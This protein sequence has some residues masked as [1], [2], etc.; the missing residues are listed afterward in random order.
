ME[1]NPRG[2]A[3]NNDSSV[4]AIF[5]YVNYVIK[6]W[7][8]V[9]ICALLCAAIGFSYAYLSY[10]PK[11]SSNIKFVTNNRAEGT[12]ALGQSSSDL[13]AGG[14]LANNYRVLLTTTR[15]LLQKVADEV[16]GMTYTQVASCIKANVIAE[17][18][19]VDF[20]ITTDNADKS[21]AIARAFVHNYDDFAQRAFPS[22]T[23][24]I[25]DEPYKA[26]KANPDNSK[27]LYTLAGFVIGAF[28]A[29]AVCCLIVAAKDTVKSSDDI[30]KKLDMK[31]IGSVGKV[32]K[33]N[34]KSAILISDKNTGFSFV[35]TF[36]LI[37]TKVESFA[38]KENAKTFVI[39]ST[40]EDEGKTTISCNL[41]LSLAKNGKSVLLIDGDLRKPAVSGTLNI[42]ANGETGLYGIIRGD[43][44]AAD[45]VRYSDKY[46][47]F[48]MLNGENIPDAAEVLSDE[49]LGKI[50]KELEKEFDYI[51]IDSAPAGVI[52]D[53]AILASEADAIIL[54]VRED[55]ASIRRIR[56][57]IEDL[58]ISNTEIAGCVYNIAEGGF[59]SKLK[60]Y[61]G[62]RKYG[63]G[64][65]YGYGRGYGYGYG[66][67]YGENK[68][69]SKK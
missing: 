35:E 54:V 45:S 49:K 41:A 17:T 7:W 67:G 29:I 39:T 33:K 48:L 61:R 62:G 58:G 59:T 44:S 56:R 12:E 55:S 37:R 9:V 21:Y 10:V 26:E 40:L 22:T 27:V 16:G 28:A 18:S 13:S 34:S 57:T 43:K 2:Q 65:G 31:L 3:D 51:I 60:S 53:T 5:N 64:Y 36:K 6:K 11:Y 32:N 1:Y 66:Y 47:L 38:A 23:L 30:T 52:A 25:F 19:I 24:K 68:K 15:G 69:K 63:Y 8:I 50:I 46:N 20:T 14:T 42:P 4:D